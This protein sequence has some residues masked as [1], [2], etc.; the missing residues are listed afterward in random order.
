MALYVYI[1]RGIIIEPKYRPIPIQIVQVI[2]V[3]GV[4]VFAELLPSCCWYRSAN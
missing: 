1:I 4:P 2:D 3:D